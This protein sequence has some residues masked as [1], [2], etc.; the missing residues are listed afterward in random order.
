MPPAAAVDVAT[1]YRAICWVNGGREK[2]EEREEKWER[3]KIFGEP[4]KERSRFGE[5][6]GRE[7]KNLV[8]YVS[9]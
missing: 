7:R 6:G 8:C 5:G 1:A 9:P 3:K 4:V 2:E